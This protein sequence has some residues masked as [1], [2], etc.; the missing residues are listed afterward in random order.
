MSVRMEGFTPIVVRVPGKV[1]LFGEHAV[2]GGHDAIVAAVDK[3]ITVKCNVVPVKVNEAASLNAE[4]IFNGSI[5]KDSRL[6]SFV[7]SAQDFVGYEDIVKSSGSGIVLSIETGFPLGAGLGSSSALCVG[8]ITC[9]LLFS[10]KID[11]KLTKEQLELIQDL[12]HKLELNINPNCSGVDTAASVWGGCIS[13]SGKTKLHSRL[14]SLSRVPINII[15]TGRTHNTAEAVAN[16]HIENA[17]IDEI[18]DSIGKV[19][20]EAY[21]Y[22]ESGH[23][24][25]N[26][27][28]GFVASL[29]NKNNELL[30]K[31]G[32]G[33]EH[34]RE[35]TAQVYGS[36]ISGAGKGGILVTSRLT[37]T[38]EK[39]LAEKGYAFETVLATEK[40][41]VVEEPDLP[42]YLQHLQ[43]SLGKKL[44]D[45]QHSV[46]TIPQDGYSSAPAN[47]AILKYWGKT[48]ANLQLAMNP[49]ISLTIPG[50]RSFTHI[51]L[52]NTKATL[53][54]DDKRANKFLRKI[55][56]LPD[57]YFLSYE[58][59]NTFP[60]SCGIA[61]SASGFSALVGAVADCLGLPKVM[62]KEDYDY[63]IMNWSRI[64]SGSASRSIYDGIVRWDHQTI[65]QVIT[66]E[67]CSHLDH[68]V[69][70]FNPMPK[71]VT[72][73]DG[74]RSVDTSLFQFFRRNGTFESM[75]RVI[76]ALK[77]SSTSI[78]D[79]QT[80][81][82]IMENDAMVMHA[83]MCTSSPP[84][85]YLNRPCTEFL[86]RFMQFRHKTGLRV[87]F[88]I[89]AGPNPHLI[90]HKD[91]ASKVLPWLKSDNTWV[92]LLI[93]REEK[94]GVLLGKQKYQEYMS[95]KL[96]EDIAQ[97]NVIFI[98][99]KRYGGKS[100]LAN[101]LSEIM[102]FPSFALS[103]SIKESYC[104]K[105][106]VDYEEM[107]KNREL[108]EEHRSKMVVYAEE[109]IASDCHV[110]DW[111]LWEK[112][113]KLANKTFI[114]S[115]G[116]RPGDLKFFKRMSNCVHV[117][118][119]CPDSVRASRGW[120]KTEVDA[121]DSETGLDDA[122]YDF[123]FQ[124]VSSET[125]DSDLQ[126]L[127]TSIKNAFS[128]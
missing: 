10:N 113:T 15:D 124:S 26:D 7:E 84:A 36:K 30:V 64:G 102:K 110:W 2:V 123:T 1:I 67:E 63:W 122:E 3:Y 103:D 117:R 91:D 104:M 39:F 47:I 55:C 42:L 51:Q 127:V 35:I 111:T 21:G 13:F 18:Y 107:L 4:V 54:G 119:E 61:S 22:F 50:F 82:H 38:D 49:S 53:T 99:G 100:W 40:G 71:K 95:Q 45:L 44:G 69:V 90:W 34:A 92:K 96:I 97:Y 128:G 80:F 60:S 85:K 20:K 88:T 70:V 62:S 68:C 116:R 114:V 66:T 106:K 37:A 73:S 81:Q 11:S 27:E 98:S 65:D 12:A 86:D 52:S 43:L 9:F 29:M 87:A 5:N 23:S 32:V 118:V 46:G 8:I 33:C 109:T 25:L 19:T 28:E 89:D 59:F 93:N 112:A 105:N 72:S 31:M 121:K 75:P 74:H 16:T 17:D 79:W 78:S 126:D 48:P 56:P 101:K 115:D 94:G 14:D 76:Q 57:E 108:K 41:V 120:K 125:S 58:S 6:I 83:V 77:K 24:S